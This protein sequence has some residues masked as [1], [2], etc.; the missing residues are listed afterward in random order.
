M[1]I[2]PY[3]AGYVDYTTRY[4]EL[5]QGQAYT[6]HAE[7]PAWTFAGPGPW[8][9]V[10]AWLDYNQD[11]VFTA[12]EQIGEISTY[13]PFELPFRLPLNAPLGATRL[14]IT[15]QDLTQPFYRHNTCLP[16]YVTA[17]T[18]DYSVVILAGAAAPL[19][20][21]TIDQN[22]SCSAT[23]QL[24]DTSLVTPNSWRWEFGDGATSSQQHP[25]HTYAQPGVYTVSL[26]VA[27]RYGQSRVTRPNY[28]QITQLGQG[29]RPT[30]CRPVGGDIVTH[31]FWE[32]SQLQTTAW[33][34]T[35]PHRLAGWQ[36][37]TCTVAALPLTA[38][39]TTGLS[40]TDPVT[41][42]HVAFW[43]QAWL[44]SNDDEVL[45]A[46]T[47]RIGSAVLLGQSQT[48]TLPLLVPATVVRNR[49]LRLR[50]SWQPTTFT[51]GSPCARDEVNGQVRDFTAVVT[52]PL[53]QLAPSS[54]ASEWQVW[55]TPAGSEVHVM[56]PHAPAT[57]Q[58]QVYDT[59]G[60]LV[61]QQP[62]AS[63]T[64]VPYVLDCHTLA[65]GLYILRLAGYPGQARIQV[66]AK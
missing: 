50:V 26:Q 63:A 36:D 48:G 52:E 6:L 3:R 60:R 14:R 22:P 37:E 51:D 41:S 44:D 30:N 27:N 57:A 61:R 32:I 19:A 55:P 31:G 4:T 56:V 35:N 8:V 53:A 20:G 49:P 64:G 34:Y 17:S 66:Q 33:T 43:V 2:R 12:S 15:I 28:V 45:D 11:G 58:L 42:V 1:E 39:T 59:L 21:F 24:R 16:D 54:G 62:L 18:E 40:L 38:G 47:E 65:A 23:V 5:T 29:P 9:R 46:A 13:S 10:A 7:A 25:Q